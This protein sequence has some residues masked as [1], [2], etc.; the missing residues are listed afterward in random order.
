[1]DL[2]NIESQE[3]PHDTINQLPLEVDLRYNVAICMECSTALAFNWIQSHLSNKHGIRKQLDEVMEYLNIQTPTLSSTEI[4]TWI[5]NVWVLDRG[6][7]GIQIK[8]GMACIKCHYSSGTK[9]SMIN[10]FGSHHKG[11]KWSENIERCNVQMPFQGRLK[12]Y[13]QIEDTEDQEV[14]MDAGNDWKQALDQEFKET[15]AGR[16]SS[17]ATGPS[18]ARL[19]SAFIAK[20]RWDLCV[21]D[22]DLKDL[23]KLAATPVKSDRL[24][25]VILCGRQY[26]EKCC[27]EL[28]G[29]NMMIKRCLMSAG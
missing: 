10:H 23:Q 4:K 3:E 28:N 21:K 26:I 15:M 18:D 13:I 6:I 12:K 24:H 29:G 27:Q 17:T 20:T 5:S 9:D 11:I 19:L 25:K 1:M 16:T 2:V 22:M 7:Q 14:E 8:E